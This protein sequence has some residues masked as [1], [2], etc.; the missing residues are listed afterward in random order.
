MGVLAAALLAAGC[1]D[2]APAPPKPTPSTAAKPKPINRAVLD[3]EGV[4]FDSPAGRT[5]EYNFGAS[6]TEV[7]AVA[8]R[9]FG[10]GERSANGECG[11]GP[12]EFTRY[13]PLTLNYQDDKLVGWLANEGVQVVTTDGVK[14]GT[15][16]RDLKVTRSVRMVADSTLEGEFD[17]LA[18]DG[19]PIG[20]FAKGKGRDAKIASLYAGTNCFFR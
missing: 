11:A 18:A 8:N 19:H 2:R 7:E 13:G 4:T 12:M 17:Y 10:D 3:H 20:G 1:H 9:L 15:F 16:M 6:R 14:P 5:F